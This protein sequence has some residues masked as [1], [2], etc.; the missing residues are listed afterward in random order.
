MLRLQHYYA[1][2]LDANISKTV[3]ERDSVPMGH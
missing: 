3:E 1:R 2:D